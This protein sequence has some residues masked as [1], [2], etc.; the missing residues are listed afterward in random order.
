MKPANTSY[1]R[2]HQRT[3]ITRTYSISEA[4]VMP[5]ASSNGK[6]SGT[7]SMASSCTYARVRCFLSGGG[8]CAREVASSKT[9]TGTRRRFCPVATL[10]T[11]IKS[12]N[13]QPLQLTVQL[14]Q[15]ERFQ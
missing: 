12:C 1:E 4:T 5:H 15:T 6:A 3:T 11:H 8:S 9:E 14:T 7:L 2:K 10:K 13:L